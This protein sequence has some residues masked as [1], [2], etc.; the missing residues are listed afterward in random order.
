[1]NLRSP[2]APN[3]QSGAIDRSA[4]SPT[5]GGTKRDFPFDV[6][7]AMTDAMSERPPFDKNKRP[8]S[9][10]GQPGRSGRPD[11][12]PFGKKPYSG[13]PSDRKPSDRKF[14]D[15][16]PFDKKSSD[17]KPSDGNASDRKPYDGKPADRKFSD[18]K[19]FDKKPS[20]RKFSDR[21]PF[22][23]NS[24]D[25]KPFDGKPSERKFSDRK[26]FDKKPSDRKFSDRKPFDKSA[27]DRKPFEAKPRGD[28]PR[29]A[30]PRD[31]KPRWDASRGRDAKRDG[32]RDDN[33]VRRERPR[34]PASDTRGPDQKAKPPGLRLTPS[35][36][37]VHAVTEAWLNPK[38]NIFHFAA[39]ETALQEFQETLAK[40]RELGL[41]RPTPEIAERYAIDKLLPP[42]SVHQGLILDAAPLQEVFVQDFAVRAS[43]MERAVVLILDQVTDPHNIGAI[44]RSANAFGAIGIVMQSRN[45]PE[46]NGV[47]AKAASGALEHMPVAYE[48]NLS[49]ALNA[50]QAEGFTAI[51]LDERGEKTL[52]QIA[53]PA[54]AVLVLGAEGKGLRQNLREHCDVVARLPTVGAI[55]SLNVSNAAAVALYALS[56]GV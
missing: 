34:D 32:Q 8:N 5:V 52:A 26:P 9:R 14:G 46:L 53:V 39:T 40:G 38:R 24:S 29:D 13:K 55:A 6:K 15:R 1:M 10:P 43:T 54:K 28:R 50:L 42:G 41:K 20:D 11:G 47:M 45:A 44:L 21:K 25:R 33:R 31:G 30:G 17:Q 27:S 37:G 2:K 22:D 7:Y 19:P 56:S 48:T 4:T 3:L 36:W 51:G 18:R 12:K 23:K 49:R 16:K 35:L